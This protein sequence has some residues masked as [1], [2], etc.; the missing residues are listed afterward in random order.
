[1]AVTNAAQAASKTVADPNAEYDSMQGVWLR[2]R[3]ICQGER[4]VKDLDGLIDVIRF[5]NLLIPFSPTMDQLQYNF[6]KAEAELPGIT[7]QFAKM[8]V[9]GLLRK[10]PTLSLPESVP[11][12]VHDW[13]INE[14][15][16]D[17]SSLTAFLDNSLWE[18]IQT[19]RAWIFVDYPKI[20]NPDSLTREDLLTY[21]PY[22]I[23]QKAETII[24]WRTRK[25]DTGKIILDR[26]IVR[27]IMESFE[28]NEFHPT[29]RDTVWVHELD[30]SDK[31][32]IRI[33]EKQ[34][35]SEILPVVAGS[36]QQDMNMKGSFI[37]KETIAD[38][39]MNGE[40]LDFIP[41]WPLNGSIEIQQPI[42]TPI[43][44]KEVALYNKIS[45]RNHLLY[46]AATYTPVICSD[47]TDEDFESIVNSG[48]GTWIRLR[49]GD[50]ASA[51]ETPTAALADMDRAIANSIEEM[52]KLGIRMLTPETDQSGI[53]LEIRNAAQTAQ[54]GSLNNKVSNTLKQ[55][56]SFMI[57][58]RY[59]IEVPSAEIDFSLSADFNPVPLGA[60]WLRLATEWYQQGL[61]PRSIWLEMLKHNDVIAPDYDDEEGQ[62]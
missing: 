19:S 24:N 43:I 8:L 35:D 20:T 30:D 4:Y 57:N 46:G 2:N 38:I 1:M 18:E 10:A 59:G 54:L 40:R 37:L 33:F 39:K 58:W 28:I 45:R 32:Q 6:Y 14:F 3:A 51:L 60:D 47:M 56:I 23:L 15:G 49:Q 62:K 25:N 11:E 31:Y 36:K 29:Y 55:I 5:S 21:K 7:S 26:V 48:L 42:L 41:A 22:P 13:I 61:I 16:A 52:A 44:D 34:N 50:T 12:E 53:A 27:G 17:D 9:G